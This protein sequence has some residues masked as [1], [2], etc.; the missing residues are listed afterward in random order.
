MNSQ[1]RAAAF[2]TVQAYIDDQN[3]DHGAF[4][5][6]DADHFANAYGITTPVALEE[7]LF[8]GAYSDWHKSEFGIRPRWMGHG[9]LVTERARAEADL[10]QW[11][12]MERVEEESAMHVELWAA[13]EERWA[14]FQA[15]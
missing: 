2:A 8:W 15:A 11:A 13:S 5:L 7:L 12:Q 1:A 4:A 3:K 14:R 6:A 10:D 9:D